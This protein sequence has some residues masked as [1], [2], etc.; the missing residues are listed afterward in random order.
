VGCEGFGD[1]LFERRKVVLDGVPD[2]LVFK[3]VIVVAEDISHAANLAPVRAWAEVFVFRFE[4]VGSFGDDL[5][6][7]A[8]VLKSARYA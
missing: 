6:L 2:G 1:G 3:A 8:W 5:Q 7:A 4:A